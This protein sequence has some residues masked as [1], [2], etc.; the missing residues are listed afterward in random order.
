MVLS[1]TNPILVHQEPHLYAYIYKKKG[2]AMFILY[3]K[4][5]FTLLFFDL[6]MSILV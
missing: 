1:L 5:P 2:L 6:M 3:F 4:I